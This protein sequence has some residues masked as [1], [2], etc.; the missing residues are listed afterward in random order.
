MKRFGWTHQHRSLWLA[1]F[2]TPSC[3][4]VWGHE[5]SSVFSR[6]IK[7]TSQATFSLSLSLPLR[8][9]AFVLFIFLFIWRAWMSMIPCISQLICLSAAVFSSAQVVPFLSH[10]PLSLFPQTPFLFVTSPISRT[11]FLSS[12]LS[13]FI[14]CFL[15]FFS[16]FYQAIYLTLPLFSSS[17]FSSSLVCG[18]LRDR[19]QKHP[20]HHPALHPP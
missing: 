9:G 15:S 4:K 12:S 16:F 19:A 10:I 8:S 5:V 20:I 11:L 13:T 18:Q 2:Q 3:V 17:P 14:F 7:I 6:V 1:H